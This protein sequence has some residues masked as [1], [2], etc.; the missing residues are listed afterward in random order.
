MQLRKFRGVSPI[1]TSSEEERIERWIL[2]RVKLGFPM[3]PE[4]LGT[5]IL[6]TGVRP[7]TFTDDRPGDKWIQLLYEGTKVLGNK[8]QTCKT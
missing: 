7:N 4:R 3:H 5:K 8:A 1:L 2:A 6:K